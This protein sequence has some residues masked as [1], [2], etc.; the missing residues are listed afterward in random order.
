MTQQ[1]TTSTRTISRNLRSPT[2][3]T[4]KE[5]VNMASQTECEICFQSNVLIFNFIFRCTG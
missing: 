3:T 2:K 5:Y 4:E 1:E